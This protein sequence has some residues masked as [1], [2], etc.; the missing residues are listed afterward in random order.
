MVRRPATTHTIEMAQITEINAKLG[1]P[2]G[3]V[4][5]AS[6]LPLEIQPGDRR[7]P[8]NPSALLTSLSWT[9]SP[10]F[11]DIFAYFRASGSEESRRCLRLHTAALKEISHRLNLHHAWGVEPSNDTLE[12]AVASGSARLTKNWAAT[13]PVKT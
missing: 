3:V 13:T 6:E 12:S 11:P 8:V 7:V 10:S 1:P 5:T 2:S 4:I 9:G